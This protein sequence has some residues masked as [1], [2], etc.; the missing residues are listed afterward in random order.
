MTKIAPLKLFPSGG[1]G[2]TIRSIP[3]G[4]RFPSPAQ[5]DDLV[6]VA[7]ESGRFHRVQLN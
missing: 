7:I 1:C 3:I 6:T 2:A 4:L 5:L